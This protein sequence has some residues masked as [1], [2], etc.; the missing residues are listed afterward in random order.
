MAA[1]LDYEGLAAK[2]PDVGKRLDQHLRSLNRILHLFSRLYRGKC[3][4]EAGAARTAL[5]MP[6]RPGPLA[7]IDFAYRM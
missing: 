6:E 3:L 2:A 7:A 5:A 1:V 4:V